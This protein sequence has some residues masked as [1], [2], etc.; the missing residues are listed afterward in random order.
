[1]AIVYL[2]SEFNGYAGGVGIDKINVK[3]ATLGAYNV[4]SIQH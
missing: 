3:I 2:N 4:E 1:M